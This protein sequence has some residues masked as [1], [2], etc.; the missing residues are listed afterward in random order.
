MKRAAKAKTASRRKATKPPNDTR[1]INECVIYAQSVAAFRDGFK[2]DPAGDSCHAAALGDRHTNRAQQ[3]LTKI[4]AT[5]ATTP[6]G[7]CSKARIVAVVFQ[8]YQ[9][10]CLQSDGAESEFLKSFAVEV[11]KFLQPICD[12]RVTPQKPVA[13]GGAS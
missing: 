2:A 9:D 6:E 10:S 13:E 5:P 7:L 12:G 11:E 4:T 3:L 8:D 1:L